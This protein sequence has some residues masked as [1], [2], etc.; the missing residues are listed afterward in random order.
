MDGF[1]AGSYSDVL[2][3]PSGL[4][5]T[6]YTNLG[7][8]FTRVKVYPNLPDCVGDMG[9]GQCV[10]VAS[11]GTVSNIDLATAQAVIARGG[12]VWAVSPSPTGSMKSNGNFQ[13]YGAMIGGS[14][15]YNTL[16]NSFTTVATLF[17]NNGVPLYAVSVQNEPNVNPGPATNTICSWTAQQIHDFVPVLRTAMNKA[18]FSAVKIMIAEEY[19]WQNDHSTIAMNDAA[20]AAQVGILAAHAYPYPNPTSTAT[21][22][23]WNNVTNQHIWMSEISDPNPYDGSITSGMTYAKQIHDWLT[24]ANV[25]SWQYFLLNNG[26]RTDNE[27]LSDN[28]FNVAKRAYVMGN[29]SK[30][31]RPGW[32]RIGATANPR[33]GVFVTAFKEVSSS[34]FAIVVLNTNGTS[35][36]QT[37]SF[38][39]FPA[40]PTAV[41]PNVT[42]AS[43][44]LATQASVNVTANAFTY[45]LPASS[46]TTFTGS[47][48]PSLVPRY[49]SQ[50]GGVFSGGSACNGQNTNNFG[51]QLRTMFS[52]TSVESA[53]TAKSTLPELLS[54]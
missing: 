13:G 53:L 10:V 26:G 34:K 54:G 47:A 22:L 48:S 15:N 21:L 52:L 37:F 36:S 24:I 40:S 46:V 14:G 50:N 38:S 23:S 30:F 6:F 20:V 4:M 43:L 18:G 17:S 35:T 45:S 8:T 51:G 28:S 2:A 33:S 11:G 1:G 9:T 39:G 12:K 27:G 19:N 25:S 31:V 29:W 16:A 44:N 49:V 7:F 5:D 42:S 3:M 41:V 32:V